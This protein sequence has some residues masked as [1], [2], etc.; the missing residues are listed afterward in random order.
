MLRSCGPTETVRMR[1][2]VLYRKIS[3]FLAS[4]APDLVLSRTGWCWRNRLAAHFV[5]WL[6]A[7]ARRRIGLQSKHPEMDVSIRGNL[8]QLLL[9]WIIRATSTNRGAIAFRYA[10]LGARFSKQVAA[11]RRRRLVTAGLKWRRM[12]IYC[13]SALTELTGH[14]H[15]RGTTLHSLRE[16][17]ASWKPETRLQ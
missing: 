17:T 9:T 10:S 12:W 5:T 6:L 3:P 2:R 7:S 14:W 13:R 8:T 16:C 4:L 15:Q 11:L 1:M